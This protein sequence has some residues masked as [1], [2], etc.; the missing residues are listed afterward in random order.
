[1]ADK[2]KKDYGMNVDFNSYG[3]K[4]A[5]SYLDSLKHLNE[6]LDSIAGGAGITTPKT[7]F[8]GLKTSMDE[9][10]EAAK[11]LLKE[12]GETDALNPSAPK[13]KAEKEPERPNLDDLLKELDELIGLENIKGNVRSLINLAKV[14]KLREEQGLPTPN[15]SLHLVFMGNPG[16]G[17]TTVA[18]LVAQLYYAIGVLSKGQLVEVDRSQLVAGFVG[19]TAIKTDEVIKKAMGGVLFIDE[20]YSLISQEGANDFGHEAVETILKAMEDHR[21]DLVVIVAGYEELMER[22]ISS[23]P[24]L[25]SRFNRY[26]VFEDYNGEELYKIFEL[27]CKKNKYELNEEAQ[28]FLKKYLNDLYETRDENFGNGRTVRNI[29]ENVVS[30]HSD[31]VAQLEAPTMDDLMGVTKEDV[32][33]ATEM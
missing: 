22:F 9:A 5:G 6:M 12:M 8:D 26:F 20:A 31:R 19:Q 14:R 27:R 25:E 21:D 30:V 16:T 23:N 13:T 29:F 11:K 17:K 3:L 10:D 2:K 1:M 32:E 7:D 33:K 24:G 18:R 28:E 4:P 15:M